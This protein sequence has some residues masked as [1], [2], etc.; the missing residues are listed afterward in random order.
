MI[1]AHAIS[2]RAGTKPILDGV[3]VH[4]EPGRVTAIVGPNG[5]GKSTLMKCLVGV[6]R[7]ATGVV[8]LDGRPLADFGLDE[9]ARRRAFLAQGHAIN[10]PFT[11]TEVVL[12]GRHPYAGEG[13]DVGDLARARSALERADVWHL[14][15]RLFPTLSGGEQQRVQI[16]RVLAQVQGLDGAFLF[17][18]EPTSALDL[19]HQYMVF[20]MLRELAREQHMAVCVIL[21]DIQLARRYAD[22][23]ILMKEGRLFAAGPAI[24]VLDARNVAELFEIPEALARDIVAVSDDRPH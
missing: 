16:A 2:W 13:E 9:L 20:D 19:K 8:H 6:L 11:A 22:N 24:D 1:E 7:P 14:R 3:S 5:S 4:L 10:F 18:D 12:L 23:A 17:L 21:H 15:E